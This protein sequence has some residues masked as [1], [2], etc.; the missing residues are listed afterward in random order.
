MDDLEGITVVAVEQ[1]VAAPYASCKLAQ[2]GARVIKIERKD[3]DFARKYDHLVRDQSAYFVWL[4]HGKES[5]CLDLKNRDD[6]MLLLQILRE[7]DV[8][9]QNLAPG[10]AH[11]LGLG[12]ICLRRNNPSLICCSIS[13]YG[14]TGPRAEQ[15]AYD[16]LIQAETGLAGIT[17][18]PDGPGRV[19]VS[20]CD[21]A[22]GMTA[23]AS[24]LQ[25]LFARTKT[26][27][28][29]DISISLFADT[30]RIKAPDNCALWRILL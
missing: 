18:S 3:G 8:F 7:A 28:G 15:K 29:Q 9:I 4:N 6:L 22:A 16:L 1:A 2:A 10:A 23:H 24:I 20:V 26:G 14:S 27:V 12:A 21:I 5:V 30:S 19:G 17:G 13:G 25:A 11:R